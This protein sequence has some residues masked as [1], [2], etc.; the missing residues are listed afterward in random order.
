MEVLLPCVKSFYAR[1]VARCVQMNTVQGSA[2][3]KG[4][5]AS[6]RHDCEG[7]Q[8]PSTCSSMR[9]ISNG[10]STST[11][12]SAIGPFADG[13]RAMLKGQRLARS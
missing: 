4:V 9:R 7:M 8:A 3:F 11:L 5:A 10:E 2:L 12:D 13:R 1:L 6:P